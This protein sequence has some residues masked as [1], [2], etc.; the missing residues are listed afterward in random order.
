[1]L[2]EVDLCLYNIEVNAEFLKDEGGADCI[3]LYHEGQGH[4]VKHIAFVEFAV[5]KHVVEEVVFGRYFPMVLQVVHK[6]LLVRTVAHP[7][8]LYLA[9]DGSPFEMEQSVEVMSLHPV[10]AP[11]PQRLA[12]KVARVTSPHYVRVHPRRS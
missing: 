2:V 3:D 1:M 11:P 9:A 6:L 12:Y 8:E 4:D 5:L 10:L 7:L